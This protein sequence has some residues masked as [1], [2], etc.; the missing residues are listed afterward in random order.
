M[1][2]GCA[3]GRW[4]AALRVSGSPPS[5]PQAL[6]GAS[7]A[8]V[9][10]LALSHPRRRRSGVECE[11]EAARRE[12]V[13][14]KK[15]R[16][17]TPTASA[18]MVLGEPEKTALGFTSTGR[19]SSGHQ[20]LSGCRNA[21]APGE[22]VANSTPVPLGEDGRSPGARDR[23]STPICGAGT[24]ALGTARIFISTH[25]GARA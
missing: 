9:D 18:Q 25:V 22:V 3:A 11:E 13:E 20:S 4:P 24:P 17:G 8:E 21:G 19:R 14:K 5:P 7:P 1:A 23:P 15:G 12:H 2:G 16:D 6:S 10:T